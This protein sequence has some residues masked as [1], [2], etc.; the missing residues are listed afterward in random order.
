[1]SNQFLAR[2]DDFQNKLKAKQEVKR[3]ESLEKYAY[4]PNMSEMSR[5]I[6]KRKSSRETSRNISKLADDSVIDHNDEHWGN[7]SK[8]IDFDQYEY[9]TEA[10]LREKLASNLKQI[11]Q[12]EKEYQR[13]S[14]IKKAVK[15]PT[16]ADA[17]VSSRLYQP[18]KMKR[19]EVKYSGNGSAAVLVDKYERTSKS[20]KKAANSS[21]FLV[22]SNAS[23]YA[24]IHAYFNSAYQ[25]NS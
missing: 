25:T 10:T 17:A 19:Q 22:Q 6:L 21:Q 3:K 13:T 5:L 1:M 23:N 11:Q 24:S 15:S 9:H 8:I 14:N 20:P 7:D 18:G 16:K 12:M 2:Q 4:K